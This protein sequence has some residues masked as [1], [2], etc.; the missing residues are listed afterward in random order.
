M[1]V[2]FNIRL[3]T[4]VACSAA[5]LTIQACDNE[6]T[7]AEVGGS[8]SLVVGSYVELPNGQTSYF[9]LVESINETGLVSYDRSLESPGVARLYP[10]PG[11]AVFSIGGGEAPTITR[12]EVDVENGTLTP[13]ETISFANFGVVNM[14]YNALT[15]LND[16][17]AYYR[18]ETQGQVITFNPTTMEVLGSIQV[19]GVNRDG[20]VTINA[21]NAHLRGRYLVY[22]VEWANFE[23]LEISPDGGLVVVD[24]QSDTVRLELDDRCGGLYHSVETADGNVYF[25]PEISVGLFVRVIGE[26]SAGRPCV[27]RLRDDGQGFDPSF[28]VYL[29]DLTGGE[30]VGNLVWGGGNQLWFERY[31]FENA[32]IEVANIFDGYTNPAWSWSSFEPNA[33]DPVATPST[34]PPSGAQALSFRVGED[35]YAIER[36]LGTAT[37]LRMTSSEG[38]TP[39]LSVPGILT[40]VLEL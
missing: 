11:N 13:G 39:G 8:P 18:D 21:F 25:G 22:S 10:A 19:P 6:T 34:R 28:V 20:F 3:L 7:D 24:T 5:A 36:D 17:K 14:Q 32:P 27:L 37:F 30:P 33:D 4:C 15:I 23:T 9:T 29:D 1:H 38:P 12:V 2:Q 26:Q 35:A 16:S 40:G 31:D